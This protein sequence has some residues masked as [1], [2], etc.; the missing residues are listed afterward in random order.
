MTREQFIAGYENWDSYKPLLWEGLE[1]SS[2]LIIELGVGKGSTQLLHDYAQEKKRILCS[3]DS[4]PKWV[5]KFFGLECQWHLIDHVEVEVNGYTMSD[6][7]FIDRHY[8]ACGLLF[9]D[10][11]P[12]ER[13]KVDIALFANKAQI[14]VAHDTEPSADHGYQMRNEIKK[15]KYCRDFETQGAWASIMSNTIDVTKPL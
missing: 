4:N 8:D 1:R 2:G 10:H 7:D 14:I 5:E 9:I 6:W 13:R 15:F 12:G 11:A 3:Y